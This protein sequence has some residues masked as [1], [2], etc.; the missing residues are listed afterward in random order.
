[1]EVHRSRVLTLGKK[2]QSLCSLRHRVQGGSEGELT[3]P[4]SHLAFLNRQWTQALYPRLGASSFFF[5]PL[6][7][8][9]LEAKSSSTE[10]PGG[11]DSR[12]GGAVGR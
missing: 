2:I 6:P 9:S 12:D 5:L 7:E 11:G 1:M 4:K 3:S 10:V 8:A